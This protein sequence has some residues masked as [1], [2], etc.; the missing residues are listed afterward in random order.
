VVFWDSRRFSWDSKYLFIDSDVG[1][2]HSFSGKACFECLSAVRS[3][4]E[5]D[6]P[7]SLGHVVEG[8]AYKA[9]NPVIDDFGNGAA[10]RGNNRRTT[11]Q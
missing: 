5:G 1:L 3:L 2:H 7:N 9:G 8:I 4:Q 10:S 11:G 6:M